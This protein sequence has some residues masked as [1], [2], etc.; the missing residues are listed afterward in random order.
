MCDLT[1]IKI[2]SATLSQNIKSGF[3]S[4]WQNGWESLAYTV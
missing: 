2:L 4:L 1:C 3:G